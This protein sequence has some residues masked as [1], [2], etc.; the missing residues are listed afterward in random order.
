M[1]AQD[2][3]QKVVTA[4]ERRRGMSPAQAAVLTAD[5]ESKNDLYTTCQRCKERIA[6][7][8]ST[9]KAHTCDGD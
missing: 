6:G 5:F 1:E 2:K 8:L 9:I 3:Q 4:L 7:T